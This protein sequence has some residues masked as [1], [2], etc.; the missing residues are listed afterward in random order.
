MPLKKFRVPKSA[1]TERGLKRLLKDAAKKHASMSEWANA[2]GIT[3][4][5]VSAFMRQQQGAGLLIP[6]KL[7]FRPQTVYLPL[8]EEPIC[9]MNPPR[10]P[11]IKPSKKVDHTLEP[12]E[13]KHLRAKDDRQETRRRLRERAR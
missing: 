5:Q 6:E 11:A 9:H 1:I 8:D 10:R 4:Q 13:K 12:V 3:P 2:N 7:G